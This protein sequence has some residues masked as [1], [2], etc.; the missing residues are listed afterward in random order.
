[1][2]AQIFTKSSNR[3]HDM[4]KIYDNIQLDLDDSILLV[5]HLE[6]VSTWLQRFGHFDKHSV[7]NAYAVCVHWLAAKQCYF[8]GLAHTKRLRY[9]IDNDY[10]C[11]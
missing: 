3:S 1:M 2:M 8:C 5:V 4:C 10:K 6:N 7:R 9:R 11:H